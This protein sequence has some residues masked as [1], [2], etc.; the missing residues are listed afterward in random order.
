MMPIAFRRQ[1]PA[2]A[3]SQLITLSAA[4]ID[5]DAAIIASLR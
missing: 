3:I 2:A 1:L 4:D 5:A